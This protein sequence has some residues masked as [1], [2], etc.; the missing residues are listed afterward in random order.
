[1]ANAES[2]L[3]NHSHA[4]VKDRYTE[5]AKIVL[6]AGTPRRRSTNYD[7]RESTNSAAE[8]PPAKKGL[9]HQPSRAKST[10]PLIVDGVRRCLVT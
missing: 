2:L 6:L 3:E 1:M 5:S 9:H 10:Q 7:G 8:D 4:D